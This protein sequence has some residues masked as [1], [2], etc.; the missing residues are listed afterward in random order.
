MERQAWEQ[1]AAEG[2]EPG[3]DATRFQALF[4]N[5]VRDLGTGYFKFS[6]DEEER[7]AQLAQLEALRS[8][9]VEQRERRQQ[10]SKRRQAKL[11][12][13]LE[14]IKR[15]RGLAVQADASAA[16]EEHAGKEE[17]EEE[18]EGDT[19]ALLAFYKAQAGTL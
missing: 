17:E 15:K 3:G 5:E 12:D 19:D 1:A 7:R 11:Q 14:R 8:D 9:T 18:E 4:P 2:G 16:V 13:R 6:T 10:L